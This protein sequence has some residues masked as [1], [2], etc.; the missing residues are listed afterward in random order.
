MFRSRGRAF[1]FTRSA[2]REPAERVKVAEQRDLGSVVQDL[3][4]LPPHDRRK[5]FLGVA[6]VRVAAQSCPVVVGLVDTEQHLASGRRGVAEPL[7]G[8]GCIWS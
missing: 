4:V 3:L 8:A 2:R 5:R 6:A 1:K 7:D